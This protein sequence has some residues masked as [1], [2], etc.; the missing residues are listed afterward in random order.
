MSTLKHSIVGAPGLGKRAGA[1]RLA[2]AEVVVPRTL[3]ADA[4]R[5][6]EDELYDLHARI[7][8]GVDKAAFVK[9]VVDSKAEHTWIQLYRGDD[10]ELGGYLAV[11]IYE[12]EVGGRLTAIVRS[13]VGTL[14]EYRG[15]NVIGRFFFDR[16]LR[17]RLA[18]PLR[19][20]Y[21]LGSLVHPS[22]YS[23]I[24]RHTDDV[25]PREGAETPSEI[26]ELMNQLGDAFG[27]ERVDPENP[28]V[29]KVGW[30]TIDSR[31]DRAFWER[32][33]RPGVQFFLRANPG[34]EDGNGLLTL[35]PAT[36]GAIT[37]GIARYASAHGSKSA[38]KL[39]AR[40]RAGLGGMVPA[41]PA[42]S[43]A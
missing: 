39:A 19:P 22:S 27:L 17:Y 26:L 15:A 37:R 33:E 14:R 8:R 31:S 5:R 24:A 40:V 21:L 6:F 23:A 1:R 36:L 9:Y 7:F 10:G 4:K 13:E 29:R 12:R 35:A 32:C 2:A 38:R 30:Q 34:Y 11:H 25:W 41:L 18:H 42:P 16:V 43:A 20:L 3:D 28:L